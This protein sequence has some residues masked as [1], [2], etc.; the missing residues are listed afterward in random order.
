MNA[1]DADLLLMERL[2]HRTERLL[3][4]IRASRGAVLKPVLAMMVEQVLWTAIALCGTCLRDA[5]WEHVTRIIRQEEQVCIIC[6]ERLATVDALC[7]ECD[8]EGR[9]EEA[10]VQFDQLPTKGAQH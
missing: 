3:R 1:H 7:Q 8:D 2:E 4:T 9:R 10:A 5:L 6:G